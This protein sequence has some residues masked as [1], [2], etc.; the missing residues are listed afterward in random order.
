MDSFL[1]GELV[2]PEFLNLN[3]SLTRLVQLPCC[4]V[5]MLSGDLDQHIQAV[6]GESEVVAPK[7]LRCHSVIQPGY[8]RQLGNAL[9]KRHRE[10]QEVSNRIRGLAEDVQEDIEAIQAAAAALVLRCVFGPVGTS[11]KEGRGAQEVAWKD[12]L[13]ACVEFEHGLEPLLR[14][15]PQSAKDAEKKRVRADYETRHA[16]WQ[17]RED[18]HRAVQ[19]RLRNELPLAVVNGSNTPNED[20]VVKVR[21]QAAATAI[22]VFITSLDVKE[23]PDESVTKALQHRLQAAEVLVHF[24]ELRKAHLRVSPSLAVHNFFTN[25]HKQILCKPGPSSHD[26]LMANLNAFAFRLDVLRREA[27][28]VDQMTS[29]ANTPKGTPQHV[30]K[31]SRFADWE[32][33]VAALLHRAE[34]V[35]RNQ[36][37]FARGVGRGRFVPNPCLA[38]ECSAF[39]RFTASLVDRRA[40]NL[41]D[42]CRIA[43]HGT[44][45]EAIGAICCR[46]FD[47][48]RRRG[49]AHGPG[50]YFG[51]TP[52]VSA[53]YARGSE[54]MLICALLTDH[55][56][57]SGQILVVNN[58]VHDVG[59]A[60]VMPLG[61]VVYGAAAQQLADDRS[62]FS[63]S[64]PSIRSG[65]IN[66]VKSYIDTLQQDSRSLVDSE[67]AQKHIVEKLDEHIRAIEKALGL[68]R[69]SRE[70]LQSLSRA[71][72]VT[73][74]HWYKCSKGHLYVIGDCGGAMTTSTCPTCGEIIGGASHRLV[75][76]N[77]SA[78]ND[79]LQGAVAAWPQ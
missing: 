51:A 75:D 44:A 47:V 46:G 3:P 64:F 24:C 37:L 67:E 11:S 77:Q 49:Q 21:Q 60:Y 36:Q 53:G 74:G 29:A 70:I 40:T 54:R 6:C 62:L 23:N 14:K 57:E 50:E 34:A 19:D 68:T 9:K 39:Q 38:R 28:E 56:S 45:T 52:E 16:A 43:F 5:I 15:L 73:A 31:S 35:V 26:V 76:S 63:C 59:T 71:L 22:R 4:G 13:D 66:K 10:I 41:A 30:A 69:P 8:Y 7:C 12:L 42:R 17:Q 18:A 72:G 20:V 1:L 33:F 32:Q 58:P 2:D 78:A 61:V 27:D 48:T 65:A 79:V 55:I 25:A